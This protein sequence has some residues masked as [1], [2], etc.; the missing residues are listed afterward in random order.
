MKYKL[1]KYQKEMLSSKN[2][3]YILGRYIG[4]SSG[5]RFYIEFYKFLQKQLWQK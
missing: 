1:N 4:R 3:Y 5:K 2:K